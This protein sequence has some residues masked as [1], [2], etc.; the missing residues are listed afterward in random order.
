M[1][2]TNSLALVLSLVLGATAVGC[3]GDPS[4]MPGDDDGG[5]GGGGSNGG[6]GG[7][8][9]QPAP[10]DVTG[11]Y[12]MR[13]TFDLATNMPGTAG[14][15][16]NTIIDATHGPNQPT[17]WILDQILPHILPGVPDLV[18]DLVAT[19]VNGALKDFIL[20]DF[21]DTLLQVGGDFGDL[22]K[23]VG[24]NETFVVTSS[25]TDYTA[26]HSVTGLHVKL[27]N[28]ESDYAFVTNQMTNIVVTNVA[29]TMDAAGH[30]TIAA[31]DVPLAYGRILQ[32]GLDAA[33]IPQIDS[34][35]HN[36]NDL[37]AHMIDCEGIGNAVA[38]TIGISSVANTI[39]TGCKVGLS[40][41]AAY[42][43][44]KISAIDGTALTFGLNGTATAQD[45]NGDR[46]ID[47][48]Q[49]GS[50]S[51]TLTYGSTPTPLIPAAFSGAR[52]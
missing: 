10:L 41:A 40:A 37:L 13:S 35:A 25:G 30:L 45:K 29:V 38:D 39:T 36:L 28:Q 26:V 43:Y 34:T 3:G 51:G 22:A 24:L 23:H 7:G 5:G 42:M 49:T 4:T 48:L 47:A 12:T 17:A 32:L 11:A 16:V 18:K 6:G 21:A 9:E 15:V 14:E 8:G 33:I 44:S 2:P 19:Y 27:G 50:W 46:K 31:H 52:M 20:P 1:K